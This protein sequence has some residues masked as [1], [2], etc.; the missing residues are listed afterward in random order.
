LGLRSE[1]S[2]RFEKGLAPEQCDHA[3]ALATQL[4][5]ELCGAA[6]A[7]G[8]IDLMGFP[9]TSASSGP[10]PPNSASSG[11]APPASAPSASPG[12]AS[13]SPIPFAAAPPLQVHLRE[14]R[15]QQIL[16]V[17]VPRERQR[18]IL[19]ALDF[20][21][22][23]AADGLDVTVPALRRQDV[24][25]EADLIEEVARIDGLEKL[26]AT[27]PRHRPAG[28]LSR[29]QRLR[30][31]A[32]DALVGRGLLETVGWTFTAP[33]TFERLRLAPADPRRAGAVALEN[34]LSEDQ[35][36][37]RTTLLGS[38]LDSA[39][40]NAARGATDLRLFE[41]G[42][43][44]AAST[45]A[46]TDPL[47]ETGIEEHRALGVLLSGAVAPAT[48]RS[49]VPQ[50]RADVY[51]V[52]GVLEGLA[53][54]LRVPVSAHAI[55]A[56]GSHPFLHPGRAAEVLVGEEPIGWLGELHPLVD[57]WDLE[58]AAIMEIDLDRLIAT[59][60]RAQD[61]RGYS[62]LIS[63]PTLRQDLAVILPE[64][65][66]AAETIAVVR[67]AAGELLTEARVFDVY[68]GAQVGEGKRSL[69][70]AL[71]FRARERTLSD[72]DIAPVRARIVA[73]LSERLGG[74]LRGG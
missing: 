51:A 38:L 5:V 54:A 57:A 12:S 31:R 74:E 36:L 11:S 23:D 71:S 33:E 60:E 48:W 49:P 63:F 40:R 1:A 35:A 46:V 50:L 67:E 39:A 47:R 34:P 14:A 66:R 53:Q 68:S 30:R 45:A 72:E 3:Q 9:P 55:D 42:T 52:K 22:R 29:A 37:L 32:V 13:S 43:V 21:V 10:A 6:P 15:V 18:A 16:G 28:L 44:F 62:D 19:A 20:G 2:G 65:V 64:R 61:E 8:K 24:T 25:R 69:A 58:G 73:A 70:L 7:P 41:V 17:A 26:P 4:L 56:P 59:A 27:L